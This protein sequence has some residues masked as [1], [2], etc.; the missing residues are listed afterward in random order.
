[1]DK[2]AWIIFGA[3]VIAILGGLVYMSQRES[4]DVSEVDHSQIQTSENEQS[5]IGDHV[6]GDADSQVVLIEY[7]DFQCPGCANFHRNFKPL[8]EDYEDKIAFVYRHFPL[9]QLHPNARAAAA[10]AEAAGRQGKYWDMH[11]LLF[12]N[13]NSWGGQ[14]GS[15]RDGVF[16]TYARELDLDIEKFNNDIGSTMVSQKINYDQS[17][18]KANGVTGTPSLFL[19]GEMIEQ[20]KYNSPEEIRKTLDA[21]IKEAENN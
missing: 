11:N 10:A 21:A 12:D 14:N 16:R 19:N 8:M 4:V 6:Y 18:G 15:Q 5:S 1:M 20:S 2:R 3:A 7:G 17:L 9:T 13:Q